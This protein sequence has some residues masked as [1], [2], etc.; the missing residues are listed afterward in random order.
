MIL[1]L[2]VLLAHWLKSISRAS[3]RPLLLLQFLLLAGS[4]AICIATGPRID[5]YAPD[6]IFAGMLGASAMA[7][8]NAL[9]Q[10]SLPRAP[11]TAVMT[12][13]ITRFAVDVGTLW[14]RV[15]PVNTAKARNRAASTLPVI[16]VF[17]F[18]CGL[19]ASCEA[20]LGLRALRCL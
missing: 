12:S 2:T 3:P 11:A 15:D 13:N 8:Q 4:L 6:A 18:G 17:T 14:L 9:V 1:S 7:V 5:P 19:G 16:V 20:A 10:I